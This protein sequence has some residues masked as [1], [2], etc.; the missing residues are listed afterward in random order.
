MSRVVI[1]VGLH[2]SGTSVV[3]G[4]LQRLGVFMGFEFLALPNSTSPTGCMED[5][6][7]LNVHKAI[8]GVKW[9]A[10]FQGYPR[11]ADLRGEEY[12]GQY[13]TL[14]ESRAHLPVWGVK[15]PHFCH[16]L[17]F[18]LRAVRTSD[19]TLV[20]ETRRP[21][22]EV[23]A[24][25]VAR[26]FVWP[27]MNYALGLVQANA[28]AQREALAT[29]DG[30]LLPLHFEDAIY[31][32]RDTAQAIADFIRMPYVEGVADFVE[33]KYHRLKLKEINERENQARTDGG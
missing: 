11:P 3:A 16:T 27:E 12:V 17:P 20:I 18:L 25:W 6:D 7:F 28:R 5:V 33:E 30:P 14:V 10:S 32:P 21:L 8:H 24:S 15:D 1:V 29:Y 26:K 23:A 22:K 4:I 2:R 31:H 9:G 13:R 19:E